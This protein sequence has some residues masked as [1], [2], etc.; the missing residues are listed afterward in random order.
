MKREYVSPRAHHEIDA[1]DARNFNHPDGRTYWREDACYTFTRDEIERLH[2]AAT[3]A[4]TMIDAA[5]KRAFEEEGLVRLGLPRHLHAA[6]TRSWRR[7]DPSLYGRF[8]FVFGPDGAPKL[9]EFNAD[10]PTALYEAA[11]M[12]WRW[13]E[14]RDRRADQYNRI[15][16]KLI[17][18]FRTLAAALPKDGALHFACMRAERDDKLTADFLADCAAQAGVLVE[19]LDMNDIGVKGA[20]IVDLHEGAITHLFKLYPWEWLADEPFADVFMRADVGV[21]EPPWRLAAASK[22]ILADLWE[23]FPNHENLLPA[24]RQI[25][26]TDADAFLAKAAFGREGDG[27]RAAWSP[28]NGP[29]VY[30]QRI[31]MPTQD[32]RYPVLGVWVVG[33]EPCG[34]GV[35]EDDEPI[36]GCNACFVPH[37]IAP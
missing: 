27:V 2:T 18:R 28:P 21:L 35:R 3:A 7:G 12:Q 19:A 30:Q 14:A 33:A 24:F 26:H 31:E 13:L 36:T 25:A 29:F 1:V 6:A 8:D 4:V 11:I 23:M 9:L 22:L 20:R 5:V 10:T 15:H 37:R 32:H 34:L 17:A 16:E